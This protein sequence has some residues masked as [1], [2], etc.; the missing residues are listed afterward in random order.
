MS[1]TGRY[2]DVTAADISLAKQRESM[3]CV[4]S[5]AIARQVVG[6]ENVMVD[7]ATVRWT[8]RPNRLRLA[9]VTPASVA[10]YVLAFDQGHNIGP[11][12]FRLDHLAWTRPMRSRSDPK[13][14]RNEDS[15][16]STDEPPRTRLLTHRRFGIR[17]VPE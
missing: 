10:R 12:R 16:R 8:D 6:A 17:S 11:F 13:R 1:V 4:V 14:W 9:Y 7:I 2:I 5:M 15:G 3:R